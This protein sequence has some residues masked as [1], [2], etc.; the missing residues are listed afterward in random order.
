MLLAAGYLEA[1]RL[2]DVLHS[3]LA[4]E[5]LI[6]APEEAN[7]WDAVEDHGQSLQAQTEG[8]AHLVARPRCRRERGMKR[9]RW[10]NC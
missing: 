7:I 4:Q 5:A 6:L 2:L 8:P 9:G 3:E 10:G 1:D